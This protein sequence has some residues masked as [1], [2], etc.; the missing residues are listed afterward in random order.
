MRLG[1]PSAVR[2]R[3][4]WITPRLICMLGLCTWR[5]ACIIFLNLRWMESVTFISF[6]N[7]KY[8]VVKKNH[9]NF[10]QVTV[11]LQTYVVCSM[12]LCLGHHTVSVLNFSVVR[13]SLFPRHSLDGV[14]AGL[15]AGMFIVKCLMLRRHDILVFWRCASVRIEIGLLSQ[16][17]DKFQH[18][19]F[20]YLW[21]HLGW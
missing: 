13:I 3:H 11:F 18:K 15:V 7:C 6:Y 21:S 9:S 14:L 5:Y 2:V 12:T 19:S 1:N 4:I 17:C 20:C 10:F 16:L 8:R